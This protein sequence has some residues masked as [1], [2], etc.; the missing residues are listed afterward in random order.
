MALGS[1]HV[2]WS[3]LVSQTIHSYEAP[4]TENYI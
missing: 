3:K 4:K 1:V 2:T